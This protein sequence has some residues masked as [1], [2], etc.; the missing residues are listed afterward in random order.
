M[1]R[2]I[3]LFFIFALLAACSTTRNIPDGE[4]LYVGIKDISYGKETLQKSKRTS[5]STDSTGII[6]AINDAVH[7]VDDLLS[8]ISEPTLPSPLEEKPTLTKE[9]T[10][11]LKEEQKKEDEY[12]DLVRNELDAVLAY[13][14]NGALFGSSSLRSPLQVR[15][16]LYDAC[17]DSHGGIRKWM[18]RRFAK[19]PV[20]ISTVSPKMRTKIAL[21]TLHNYGYFSGSVNHEVLT[22]RN[23]KKAK[24]AYSIIPGRPSRYDSIEYI[25]FPQDLKQLILQSQGSSEIQKNNFFSA[26]SLSNE[27]KRLERLFREHGYYYYNSSFITFKADTLMRPGYVQLRVEHQNGLP[28]IANRPFHIGH[29]YV[30]LRRN[31]DEV[32]DK[33]RTLR[34]S[35]FSYGGKK[36]AVRPMIIRRAVVHRKGERYNLTHQE[37]TFEKLGQLNTFSSFDVQYIPRD[38]TTTC[39]TLDIY[40][41]AILD[42]LYDSSFEMNATLKSNDQ[43]GPGVAYSLAKRNAFGGAEKISWKI[44]GSYEWQMN[45]KVGTS[46]SMLNSYEMGTQLAV[47]MPRFVVP[48]LRSRHIRFPASTKFALTGSWQN[49]AKFF[50]MATM[51]GSVTYNWNRYS[52]ALHE[53]NVF[54]LDYN[55]LLSTTPEFDDIREHNPAL[56]VSM[57]N[58]FVPS[59]SYTFTY[60]TAPHHRNH[61]WIQTN[62][63]QAGNLTSALFLLAGND[64]NEKD[65]NILGTPFA[66][67]LKASVEFHN[68]IKINNRSYFAYRFFGGAIW[69]YGNST[70][71]PYTDQFYVGGA[72]S[73]RGFAARTL[74]PG[75]YRSTA[76]KYS[77]MEQTGD[78]KLEVNA[79]YRMRLFADLHAAVFLD[80]GNVWLMKKDPIRP[81]SEISAIALNNIAVGTGA[82]LRYDLDFLVLRFDVGVALHAPYETGKSGWYNIPNFSDGFAYH[83]AIGYPF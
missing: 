8:G 37:R 30:V 63:K 39:D 74:G 19:A 50:K 7:T 61:L 34:S 32:V 67:F 73:V 23:P 45:R 31:A 35:T 3:S 70:T 44:Y 62:I 68:H 14:P 2:N 28:T 48:F 79:E 6:I 77:Y 4:Q 81:K 36:M 11:R 78:V 38:T 51:G 82:G 18:F 54:S 75:A 71:A 64:F 53:L 83:F 41:S 57:R 80:A 42:K 24:I 52:N 69:N 21:N 1:I 58:T 15:L 17:Y 10:E 13:S 9:E 22:Q 16:R 46:T 20:L 55:K 59:T 5:V 12:F 29:T 25:G 49:R 56:Y 76:S 26:L 66:Q 72:N 47:E 40:V 33:T 60:I 27:K 43:I 65:K